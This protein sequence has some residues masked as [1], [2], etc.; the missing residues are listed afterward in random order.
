M[1]N[2]K[3]ECYTQNI[4]WT[5]NS[6]NLVDL[7]EGRFYSNCTKISQYDK[8]FQKEHT[9]SFKM[10]YDIAVCRKR[11]LNS[12]SKH[13]FDIWPLAYSGLPA[14]VTSVRACA[15]SYSR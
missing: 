14:G 7:F 11:V 4:H 10:S 2:Y 1:D 8:H 12:K 9:L 6:L 15:A 3:S 13:F 5:V